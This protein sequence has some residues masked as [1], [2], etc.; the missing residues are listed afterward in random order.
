MPSDLIPIYLNK[1]MQSKS[2]TM[3]VLG[4]DTKKFAI[5]TEPHVGKNLQTF[6]TQGKKIRPSS[7]D[8]MQSIFKGYKIK[9]LQVVIYDVEDTTYYA[10]LFLQQEN[11]NKI[12]ILE[13]DARP[14]D[15]L[16]LAL[17]ENI[18]VYCRKT[19]M[20]KAIPVLD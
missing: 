5:Y 7:H 11:D 20:E 4:D 8:L 6:L 19:V 1:I 2:Y 12:N 18:P 17:M 14:S 16:T 15:C 3:M 13:L 9:P 10:R